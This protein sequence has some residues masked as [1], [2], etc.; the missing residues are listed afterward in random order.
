MST[1]SVRT[2]SLTV[3]IPRTLLAGTSRPPTIQLLAETAR[4]GVDAMPLPVSGNLPVV[5]SRITFPHVQH[6]RYE[7]WLHRGVS[8]HTSPTVEVGEHPAT[9]TVS[10]RSFKEELAEHLP[11]HQ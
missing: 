6:G 9:L 3:V 2:G 11:G 5:S 7:V 4:Y 8:L 10:E 1:V